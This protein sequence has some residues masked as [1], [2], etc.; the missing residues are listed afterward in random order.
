MIILQLAMVILQ[1]VFPVS[2]SD[3]LWQRAVA[4]SAFNRDLVPGSWVQREEVFNGEGESHLTSRKHVAFK[5]IRSKVDISLVEAISNGV[6][7]TMKL[8]E[9]FDETHDQFRL[10]AQFNPFQPSHQSSVSAKRDGRT[11]RDGEQ[12]LVAYDYSQKTDDGR[13]RGIAW[14]DDA[15]GMP[16]HL[17]ARLTGLPKMDGKDEIREAVLNVYFTSGPDNAWYPSKIVL[18]TRVILNNFPYTKF[19]GSIETAITLDD[20]WKIT[21]H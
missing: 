8:R 18:F 15:T 19:Y 21:F 6:D 9:S 12:V 14:I 13:W 2:A 16:T 5:Q 17:T 20:Y 10:R 4:I 7:I 1:W 3:A 11:R